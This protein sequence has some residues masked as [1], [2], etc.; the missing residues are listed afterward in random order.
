MFL[1]PFLVTVLDCFCRPFPLLSSFPLF[2]C[3]LMANFSVM[4]E[5]LFLYLCVY[6]LYWVGQSVHL[7]LSEDLNELFGQSN[8]FL[9]SGYH[10]V[11][12]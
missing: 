10:E 4:F 2:S 3:D 9:V 7:D 11:L 8:R 5:F 12:I 1:L 6:L